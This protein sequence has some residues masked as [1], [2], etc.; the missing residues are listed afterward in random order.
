M[1]SSLRE[2][3]ILNIVLIESEK[4]KTP[5][6]Y[7]RNGVFLSIAHPFLFKVKAI[8]LKFNVFSHI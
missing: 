4:H 6:L 1:M 2:F 8:I 7:L 3:Y 5:P